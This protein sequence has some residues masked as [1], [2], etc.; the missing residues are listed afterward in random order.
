MNIVNIRLNIIA[1]ILLHA[2]ET[3][4]LSLSFKMEFRIGQFV[5]YRNEKNF[6][7]LLGTPAGLIAI[8]MLNCSHTQPNNNGVS[9]E[10]A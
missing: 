5:C 6:F 7:S 8:K 4:N 10:I 1:F 3:I 2:G 9:L